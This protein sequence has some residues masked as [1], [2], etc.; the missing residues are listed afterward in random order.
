M[1]EAGGNFPTTFMLKNALV[2]VD[3][4]LSSCFWLMLL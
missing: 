2:L 1:E 3:V 4:D